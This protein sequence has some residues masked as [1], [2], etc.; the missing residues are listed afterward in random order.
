[1][2]NVADIT[3]G[4]VSGGRVVPDSNVTGSCSVHDDMSGSPFSLKKAAAVSKAAGY[5]VS[6]IFAN[7][8]R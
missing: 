8:S 7:S 5:R 6:S 4:S 3:R 2:A 1:M